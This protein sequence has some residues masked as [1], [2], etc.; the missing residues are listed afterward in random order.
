MEAK[1]TQA[2]DQSD[3][4][5]SDVYI[6]SW[7]EGTIQAANPAVSLNALNTCWQSSLRRFIASFNIPVCRLQRAIESAMVERRVFKG[8]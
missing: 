3:E 2:D 8:F 5:K 6:Y 7:E 4:L 1:S